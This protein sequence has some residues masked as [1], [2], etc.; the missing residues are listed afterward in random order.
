MQCWRGACGATSSSSSSSRLW[1]SFLLRQLLLGTHIHLV[2]LLLE[3]LLKHI[4]L[5]LEGG[6]DELL[7]DRELLRSEVPENKPPLRKVTR[8][9]QKGCS[10]CFTYS[11][12]MPSKLCSLCSF[13]SRTKSSRISLCTAR[14]A[15]NCQGKREKLLARANIAHLSACYVC[16]W[17]CACVCVWCV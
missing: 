15:H 17:V 14:F 9:T 4:A 10:C 5:Q 11:A 7:L 13:C 16:V 12:L 1:L 6:R 3:G 2:D 8:E